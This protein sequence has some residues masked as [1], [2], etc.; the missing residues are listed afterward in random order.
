M[1]NSSF[2]YW[3]WRLY[4]GGITY[5][6]GLLLQMPLFYDKLSREDKSFFHV[7]ATEMVKKA[8]E[9]IVTKNNIGIQENIKYPRKYRNEIN[10]RLLDIIGIEKESTIFDF[11]HSNMALEVNV[12]NLS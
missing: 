2:C 11:I 12:S 6:K 8:H 9:F 4:D 10:Q 3:H 1:V 5:P 7:K